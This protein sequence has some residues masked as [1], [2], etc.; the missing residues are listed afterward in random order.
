VEA[1]VVAVG[2]IEVIIMNS[3]RRSGDFTG[4]IEAKPYLISFW[5]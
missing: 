2:G 3:E 5:K 1:V 4:G